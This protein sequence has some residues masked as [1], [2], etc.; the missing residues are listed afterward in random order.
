MANDFVP[1]KGVTSAVTA[2]IGGLAPELERMA[3]AS[4]LLKRVLPIANLLEMQKKMEMLGVS[5]GMTAKQLDKLSEANKHLATS[6]KNYSRAEILNLQAS[7]NSYITTLSLSEKAQEKYIKQLSVAFPNAAEEA[8]RTLLRLKKTIPTLSFDFE[9]ASLTGAEFFDVLEKGGTESLF[10][11]LK[12]TEKAEKATLSLQNKFNK[13]GVAVEN[14]ALGMSER[15]EGLASKF[16]DTFSA[17]DSAGPKFL[18]QI[19]ETVIAISGISFAVGQVKKTFESVRGAGKA[20]L[21][22]EK[23]AEETKKTGK[24]TAE[25][26]AAEAS[27]EK[28]IL[29]LKEN[30]L[31]IQGNTVTAKS[32]AASNI[33]TGAIGIGGGR[34]GDNQAAADKAKEIKSA[35]FMRGIK[36]GGA[37]AG[38][39]LA[40]EGISAFSR[41]Q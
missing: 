24:T 37:I 35:K 14:S 9:K 17:F 36:F 3:D 30:T 8:N 13:M 18:K 41:Y 40:V 12:A 4:G 19:A 7:L 20:I 6:I 38:I 27:I 34:Y 15:I 16:T 21:G 29:A 11:Y 1:D 31:A 39:G 25:N 10:V 2:T 26:I 22:I 5:S 23:T 33:G 32:G 28:L